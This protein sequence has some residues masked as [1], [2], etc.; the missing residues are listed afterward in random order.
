MPHPRQV[1][2]GREAARL[3]HLS[4]LARPGRRPLEARLALR[5]PAAAENTGRDS[6]NTSPRRAN[7]RPLLEAGPVRPRLSLPRRRRSSESQTVTW[8]D[9]SRIVTA[10]SKLLADE[11][12][13]IERRWRKVLFLVATLRKAKFDGGGD[14]KKAVTGGRLSELLHVLAEAPTDEVPESPDELPP[15]G[16]VGRMVFRS[17]RSRFTREGQRPRSRAGATIGIR[18]ARLGDPVR[19][20]QGAR[21]ARPRRNRRATFADAEKPLGELSDH[22]GVTADALG[23]A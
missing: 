7:S 13:T 17:A 18:P 10:V 15:P 11:D 3:P 1:R 19:A 22:R 9:F 16:W 14:P 20:R 6:P 5:V 21:A 12:D 8:S 4:V 23:R 2:F